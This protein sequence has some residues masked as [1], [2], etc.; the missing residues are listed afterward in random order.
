MLECVAMYFPMSGL[1]KTRFKQHPRE[2]LRSQEDRQ[3]SNRQ[4][5]WRDTMYQNHSDMGRKGDATL[6][7]ST[8]GQVGKGE[9]K[10]EKK[11]DVF[12]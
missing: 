8:C 2:I 12:H 3:Q 4:Q 7:V 5:S 6:L 11:S 1:R 9:K 10:S